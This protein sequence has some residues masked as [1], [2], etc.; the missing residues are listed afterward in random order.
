MKRAAGD[1]S[2]GLM[3]WANGWLF[4]FKNPRILWLAL[5][6]ML[7]AILGAAVLLETAYVFVPQ[8]ITSLMSVLHLSKADFLYSLLYYPLI[9]GTAVLLFVLG[10][11]LI[12]ILQSILA[13]PFYSVMADRSLAKL[14]K[15]PKSAGWKMALRM[16]RVGLIKSFCFVA[17]ALVLFVFSF[18][19]ILNVA[20]AAC[21]MLL[22]AFD[23]MDYSFEVL[24]WG[25]RRRFQYLRREWAQWAGMAVGL[26]LTLLIPGLTLL[27]IPG[28]VVGGALIV[29]NEA[30]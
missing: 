21:A 23:T 18:L 29:K 3:Y 25:L 5:F 7:L 26:A 1:F 10:V 19:P 28:A 20:A 24:G 30:R 27:V 22:L 4:M 13:I 14:G 12:Y 9:L 11:Y 17:F 6:P 16:V 15:K 2:R 8:G